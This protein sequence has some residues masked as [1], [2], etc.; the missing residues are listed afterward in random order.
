M[1]NYTHAFVELCRRELEMC[2]VHDGEIVAVLSQGDMRQDYAR[3]FIDAA[4]LL[5]ATA[6]HVNIPNPSSSLDGEFGTWTVG[7]TPLANNRPAIDALKQADIVIDLMFLLFSLT[8]DRFLTSQ[9]LLNIAQQI[10]MLTIVGAG[11]TFGGQGGSGASG[12]VLI[13]VVG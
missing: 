10:S 2:K 6:Y 5:G 7:Q 8:V 13:T 3:A 12:A 11:L 9:N 1:T 4:Q